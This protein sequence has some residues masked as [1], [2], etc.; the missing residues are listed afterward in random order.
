ML[1]TKPVTCPEAGRAKAVGSASNRRKNNPARE[2]RITRQC[3]PIRAGCP[4]IR[5]ARGG[6]A[7]RIQR[8]GRTPREKVSPPRRYLCPLGALAERYFLPT[9]A[10]RST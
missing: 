8:R 1:S 3:T 7:I 4:C 5:G 2:E 6:C 10:A 9:A